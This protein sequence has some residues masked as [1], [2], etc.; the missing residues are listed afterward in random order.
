[1]KTSS[2]RMAP[3][4][5]VLMLLILGISWV[6]CACGGGEERFTPPPATI[7]RASEGEKVTFTPA[8]PAQGTAAP[9]SQGV[10]AQPTVVA[11]ASTAEPE[12]SYPLPVVTPKES[13][14]PV[15]YPAQ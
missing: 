14:T 6:L 8:P 4:R 5:L 3:G 9:Q 11:P 15:Q 10:T 13:P 1:M 2:A 7:I 12:R